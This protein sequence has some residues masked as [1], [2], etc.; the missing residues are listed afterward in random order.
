MCHAIVAIFAAL[1]AATRD[2]TVEGYTGN[3]YLL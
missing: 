3:P 2:W 1:I